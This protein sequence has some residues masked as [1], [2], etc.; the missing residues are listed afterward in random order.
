MAKLIITRD[1]VVVQTVP[2]TKDRMTIGRRRHNDIV[3][4][5][6]TVSG[7]HAVIVTML[8]D[9]YIEDLNSTNGTFVNGHRI[10]KHFLQHKNLITLAKFEME[11]VSDGVRSFGVPTGP[12]VQGHIR[13]LNGL[14]AGKQLALTK[15]QT[16]LGRVGTQVVVITRTPDAYW[17][18]HVEGD[19]PPLLNGAPAGKQSKRLKTGDVVDLSGIQMVFTLV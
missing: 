3:L 14:N 12:M 8:D 7:E 18:A 4:A 16:T 15:S 6:S 17:I 11:F 19:T 13:I 2:L 5:D 9:S 10:G 1:T